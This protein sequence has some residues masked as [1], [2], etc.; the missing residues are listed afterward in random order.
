MQLPVVVASWEIECCQPDI[1]VG[2]M[3]EAS[4]V[5][6]RDVSWVND[7]PWPRDDY[8]MAVPVIEVEAEPVI[9]AD[10]DWPLVRVNG[11]IIGAQDNLNSITRAA[12]CAFNDSHGGPYKPEEY[13]PELSGI[14]V[15]LYGIGSRATNGGAL[16]QEVP[17]KLESTARPGRHEWPTYNRGFQQFLVVLDIKTP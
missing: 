17:V 3:W 7:D 8:G 1:T 11:I 16:N 10:P 4:P 14:A 15:E 12:F 13:P 2:E 5:L 6:S 9:G